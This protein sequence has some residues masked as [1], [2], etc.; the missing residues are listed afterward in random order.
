MARQSIENDQAFARWMVEEI[1]VATVPGSSFYRQKEQGR[2]K[3]R[4]CYCKKPETLEL[5]AQILRR[6]A[7]TKFTP[8]SSNPVINIFQKLQ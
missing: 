3:I 7:A 5:A 8:S 1:G 6:L 2:T 4:F